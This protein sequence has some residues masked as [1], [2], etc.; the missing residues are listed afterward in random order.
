M[1]FEMLKISILRILL[2]LIGVMCQKVEASRSRVTLQYR[3]ELLFMKLYQLVNRFAKGTQETLRLL[4]ICL[5]TPCLCGTFLT[6]KR[7]SV[8][9]ASICLLSK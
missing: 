1:G 6:H 9:S 7:R 3:L 2:S 5:A 8:C 4:T